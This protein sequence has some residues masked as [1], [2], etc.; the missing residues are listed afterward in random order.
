VFDL[1]REALLPYYLYVKAIHLFFVAMWMWS[2]AAAYAYY[3]VPVFKAW[4]RNP[5][6]PG[7]LAMRNWAIE[8]FDQGATY[9][10]IAFPAILLTGPLLYFLA[11]WSTESGWLALK[12]LIVLGVF[13]PIEILD[14]HLSHLGGNKRN[15]RRR[16]D[17]VAYERA[18]HHHWLFLILSSPVVMVFILAVIALA[19]IKPF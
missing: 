7:V 2:T 13:L 6:D 17:P 5:R 1:L 15:V 19:V 16:N 14:Y 10:H 3:L 12:L 4:R 8:R 11:G 9:E 18:I